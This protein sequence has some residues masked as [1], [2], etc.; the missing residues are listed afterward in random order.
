MDWKQ[1]EMGEVYGEG[2][3]GVRGRWMAG[4]KKQKVVRRR[5]EAT[6]ENNCCF[7][8]EDPL[9]SDFPR[10]TTVLWL[11]LGFGD[12]PNFPV[13]PRLCSCLTSVVL[14]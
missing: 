13:P 1:D 9:I 5:D 6:H 11:S 3:L 14:S 12:E 8:C 4:R 10:F 7:T 2:G